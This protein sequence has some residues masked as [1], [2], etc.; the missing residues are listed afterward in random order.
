MAG[1]D[2]LLFVVVRMDRAGMRCSP[3]RLEAVPAFLSKE[4]L[5]E[6]V[7]RVLDLPEVV[8]LVLLFLPL[9]CSS[10]RRR[11]NSLALIRVGALALDPLPLPFFLPPLG[12]S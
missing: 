12:P 1:F 3:L 9:L 4:P 7:V 2:C 10:A 8:F 11:I 6:E 5:E